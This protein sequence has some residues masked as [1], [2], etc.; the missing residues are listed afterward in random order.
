MFPS[1]DDSISR[2]EEREER[3]DRWDTRAS[4][5]LREAP[6]AKAQGYLVLRNLLDPLLDPEVFA[7]RP[8]LGRESNTNHSDGITFARDSRC[9]ASD[10]LG[11]AY[12]GR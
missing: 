10:P 3:I 1:R 7:P 11:N 6:N 4:V 9:T 2:I 12:Y 5:S 8:F